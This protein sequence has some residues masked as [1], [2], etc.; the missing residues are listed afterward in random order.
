VREGLQLVEDALIDNGYDDFM[1][2]T[3][4]GSFH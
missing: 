1:V 4:H 3:E 2:A